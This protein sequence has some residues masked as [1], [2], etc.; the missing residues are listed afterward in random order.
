MTR[1][2]KQKLVASAQAAGGT[3]GSPGGGAPGA[4]GRFGSH[5]AQ[6]KSLGPVVPGLNHLFL[7]VTAGN[8]QQATAILQSAL[9]KVTDAAAKTGSRRL[10]RLAQGLKR[11]LAS[12]TSVVSLVTHLHEN[13]GGRLTGQRQSGSTVRAIPHPTGRGAGPPPGIVRPGAGRRRR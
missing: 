12:K 11:V 10:D 4:A 7:S 3:M 8:P 6:G 2:L 13:A 9:A 1:L 5:P